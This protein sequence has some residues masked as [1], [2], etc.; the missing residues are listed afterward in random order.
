MSISSIGGGQLF[1]GASG[2]N[3]M[4]PPPRQNGGTGAT[5]PLDAVSSL[6]GMSKDEVASALQ[7]GKS[8]NDLV[9]S[10]G[11]SHE[12]L[13]SA[14][15]SG[16]PSELAGSTN[17]TQVAEQIASQTGLQGP[18]DSQG[19]SGVQGSFG[20]QGVG[21][22]S[23]VSGTSATSGHHHHHRGSATQ[24]NGLDRSVSGVFGSSL[25]SSQQ[26]TVDEL[27]SLLGTDSN[28]L[29]TQLKNGT[30]L[31]D[32]VKTK[33]VDSGSLANVIQD[34]LLVDTKS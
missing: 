4:P 12:D 32:L 27:S 7:Q 31:A 9:T 6:L 17:A 13:I 30:S 34:G 8:L 25:N 29:L 24:L 14:L 23:D 2:I 15:K 21:A 33:G 3:R 19:A 5:S 28:T 18:P 22:A 10:K 11:V 16:M 1:G 26:R 20:V